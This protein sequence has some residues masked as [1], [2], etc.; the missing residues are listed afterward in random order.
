MYRWVEA[1]SSYAHVLAKMRYLS[2]VKVEYQHFPP[3]KTL[4]D[5]NNNFVLQ[6]KNK[7]LLVFNKTVWFVYNHDFSSIFNAITFIS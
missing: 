1:Q 2:N 6:V 3:A 7:I 5:S 4:Y